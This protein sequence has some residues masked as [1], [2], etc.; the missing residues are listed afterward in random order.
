M[1]FD[2]A[3]LNLEG[4]SFFDFLLRF[5]LTCSQE[6]ELGNEKTRHPIQLEVI[7]KLHILTPILR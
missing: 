7:C 6:I 3:F 4:L 1:V 5:L 2:S